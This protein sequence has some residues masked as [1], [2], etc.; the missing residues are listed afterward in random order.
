M[1][2]SIE[3]KDVKNFFVKKK[4]SNNITTKRILGITTKYAR[5][6][7]YN[8]FISTLEYLKPYIN[9]NIDNILEDFKIK[10]EKK[11]LTPEIYLNDK[12]LAEEIIDSVNPSDI[13]P[14]TGETRYFQLKELEFAKEILEDIEK[15]T[16][17]KPFMD[18]G[19]LLG[20]VRHK[21]F[22]PWDDDFD[23]SL[24]R[25]DYEKLIE[26]FK[27]KYTWLDTSNW[28]IKTYR[29]DVKKALE[30]LPKDIIVV[31][32]PTSLKLY[33]QEDNEI[34][35]LD[36]FVLDY[37]DDMLNISNLQSLVK[38]YKKKS[39][40]IKIFS[41]RL[42]FIKSAIE[43]SNFVVDESNSIQVG[44]DNANFYLYSL[45][46]I[47]RKSDIFPLIKMQFEDTEFYAPN[48][49]HEYL[50]TI[51]SYYDK[52]PSKIK[53]VKHAGHKDFK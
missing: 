46:G 28:N 27:E 43:E 25:K 31:L 12:K 52:L 37:Y 34:L 40:K 49:T 5:G 35:F 36:F 45:K 10:A 48:N 20:A 11:K 22:I 26:Y 13:T 7:A 15:N 19:T 51:Y 8:N 24:M 53:A 21:G 3:K 33:K 39:M 47:R 41:E 44:I 30:M 23:F 14:A 50:K 9:E 17:L 16:D 42:D 18:D 38:K 6:R 32:T 1:R 4:S 2:F 29:K